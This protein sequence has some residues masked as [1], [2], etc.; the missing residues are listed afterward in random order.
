MT[1]VGRVLILLILVS[2]AGHQVRLDGQN[3][4][5]LWLENV[6]GEKALSWVKKQNEKTLQE[7]TASD[8]Y[9]SLE[10][11]ALE[12]LQAKDK[13][14]FVD[15][16]GDYLYNFWQDDKH[17]RG[18]WRRT[19]L[20][21]YKRKRPR[22]ETVL[23]L[24][25]LSKKEKENWV[26][27]GANCRPPQYQRCLLRLSRGGKD[28]VEVREFDTKRKAFVKKGFYLREAKSWVDWLDGNHIFVATNEGAESLTESGYPRLVKVWK[29]GTPLSQAKLV[30]EAKKTD[31]G[32]FA[33]TFVDDSG[34][35][36]LLG[37]WE[38]FFTKSMFVYENGKSLSIPL[39]DSAEIH[40]LFKNHFIVE[41]RKDW[42]VDEKVYPS[43]SLIAVARRVVK[44]K[45][46]Q[47][48][49]VQSLFAPDAKSSILRIAISKD[50]VLINALESV[51]G[52]IFA[53]G[54]ERDGFAKAKLIPVK[55]NAHVTLSSVSP[56]KSDFFF[57]LTGFLSPDALYLHSAKSQANQKLKSLPSK[58][59]SKGMTVK[60]VWATSKDGTQVPYF[61]I[62][63]SDVIESGKAPTLLYGYGGFEI[64]LTPR[65]K[66]VVG[67]LWLENGGLYVMANI[68]GGGEFGPKWHQSALKTK[69]HKAY[70][71][72]IAVGE[73][74][75]KRGTTT[76]EKLA[77]QGGS[78][79]GLLVGAVMTRRPDLF[80]AVLCHVPLLDMIRYSQLLAGASWVG[81]YGDPKKSDM[82][83]YLLGYSP[84]HNVSKDEDYPELFL[85]TSTKDDRVHPGHARK[86]AAKMMSQGHKNIRYYE[87]TEGGHAASAN[88]KQKARM[89]ALSYEFLYKTI[90]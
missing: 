21:S 60:Q 4:P 6:E 55:D 53:V 54:W 65:Y 51:T 79:G 13:I 58:F 71:D 50:K 34:K 62:G 46:V 88:L 77:I 11:N 84:Y 40:G 44:N 68:R 48:S 73:D 45:K 14:P 26:F 75:I 85:M 35:T 63:R 66:P 8:R 32:G 29:R 38:T 61:L 39:Q 47:A 9:K 16:K 7:I 31:M 76:K 41:L 52:K 74:L 18:L 67:K 1:I 15:I 28:A 27:K 2:C 20:N 17:V 12:I 83:N 23:D 89:R 10:K 82:K 30:L 70:D 37:R 81:E 72:F 64:S 24:D 69:R 25:R 80:K 5:H 57:T 42:T 36:A 33:Q 59:S 22:W 43:G 3:D 19:T 86:M 78:N 90:Q 87:N 49:D 56:Y